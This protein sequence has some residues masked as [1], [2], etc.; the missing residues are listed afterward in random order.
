ML[1]GA[2]FLQ[3]LN[4]QNMFYKCPMI[5]VRFANTKKTLTNAF[6]FANTKSTHQTN[7]PH[8]L[9]TSYILCARL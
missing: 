4:K 1:Y 7:T 5:H 8:I 3:K 2:N 9:D 6:C